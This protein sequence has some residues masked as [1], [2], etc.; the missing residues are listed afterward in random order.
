MT[1]R[2]DDTP[3]PSTMPNCYLVRGLP[4]TRRREYAI[5]TLGV[6]PKRVFCADDFFQR[7][8]EELD[9][10]SGY[11]FDPELIREAHQDCMRRLA[12]G[13]STGK[14]V[15]V[16]NTFSTLYEMQSYKRLARMLGYYYVAHDLFDEGRSD[17]SL[18]ESLEFPI[19]EHV[20]QRMRARWNLRRDGGG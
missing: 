13:M 14:P 6:D 12:R 7:R 19:P 18:M 2:L 1:T 11:A 4:G 16:T 5:D 3:Q 8:A 15:A 10:P 9:D 17:A 20:I